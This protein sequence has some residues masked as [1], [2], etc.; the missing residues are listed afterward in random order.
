[1]S[2]ETATLAAWKSAQKTYEKSLA[3]KDL[4]QLMIPTGPEDV[5]NR[6][7]EWQRENSGSRHAK[8]AESIRAGIAPIKR[9]S[10]S[11]DMMAQGSPAPA[12]LLWGSIKFV[13]TVRLDFPN[14]WNHSRSDTLIFLKPN[15]PPR[16][17]SELAQ[18]A[19]YLIPLL[20]STRRYRGI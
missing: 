17:L 11:I 15:A 9:F 8:V 16:L 6:I 20:D 14:S 18:S 13:L 1:M 19:D 2:G 12:C 3:E 7:E 4:K 5:L 10:D